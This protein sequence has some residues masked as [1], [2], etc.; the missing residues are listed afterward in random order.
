MRAGSGS[1]FKN[2]NKTTENHPNLTG[3]IMLPDGA[4]H[5]ISGWTKQT[6]GGDKYISVSIG[7]QVD[8]PAPVSAH[9]QAKANGYQPQKDSDIPF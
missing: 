4:V 5:Y 3:K 8:Q 1:L 9:N 2:N 7:K 6:A